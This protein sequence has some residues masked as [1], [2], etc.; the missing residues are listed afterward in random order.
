MT[1]DQSGSGRKIKSIECFFD[2]C[3]EPVNPG[4]YAG[5][6]CVVLMDGKRIWEH[7]GFI[8]KDPGTSN[9]LAEYSGFLALL[10]FL[11]KNRLNRKSV[12]F[13]G[14][15]KLVLYQMFLDPSIGRPWKMN[16]G[17]YFKTAMKAKELLKKFPKSKCEWIPREENSLADELSKAEL[18]KRGVVFKIQPE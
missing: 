2:G 7:S 6:G 18:L 1:E 15:S 4:G 9:N 11:I 10:E 8:D 3:T 14:D 17:R 12:M 13:F 5:Y 16:G